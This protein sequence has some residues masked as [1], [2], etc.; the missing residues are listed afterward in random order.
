MKFLSNSSIV[1]CQSRLE[2]KTLE[3]NL[4]LL[5]SRAAG[6]PLQT[7]RGSE[8]QPPQI[9]KFLN[10]FCLDTLLKDLV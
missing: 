8:T 2:T 9:G 10:K 3:A 1:F 7:L 5:T 4:S 6:L